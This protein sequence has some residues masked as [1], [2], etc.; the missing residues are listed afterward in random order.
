MLK[1][2][3]KIGVSEIGLLAA[4]GETNVKVL[5]LNSHQI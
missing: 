5:I 2:G 4:V 3:E 1:E